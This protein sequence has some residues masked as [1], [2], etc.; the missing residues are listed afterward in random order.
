MFL[1]T[2]PRG[3][4]GFINSTFT[5]DRVGDLLGR[6][7]CLSL[8]ACSLNAV[9]MLHQTGRKSALGH[10]RRLCGVRDRS[11]YP[12]QRTLSASNDAN[13]CHVAFSHTAL[14]A[15]HRRKLLRTTHTTNTITG[16][17][18]TT[19]ARATI[20]E[21]TDVMSVWPMPSAA[22]LIGERA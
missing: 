10:E 16:S 7:H 20:S 9:V 13:G 2:S 14:R 18:G 6:C 12:Q 8:R 5:Q 17:H 1:E 15:R 19:A 3:I 22:R 11:A 21:A 4:S